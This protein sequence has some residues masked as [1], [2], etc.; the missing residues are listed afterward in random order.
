MENKKVIPL[1]PTPLYVSQINL[2]TNE[3]DF[4]KN[5]N[6]LRVPANNGFMSKDNNI[7]KNKNLKNLNKQ[8]IEHLK[9]YKEEIFSIAN[10]INVFIKH[11]WLMKHVKGDKS[12][13]HFHEN[14]LI[15]GIVYVK[16][17]EKSGNIIFHKKNSVINDVSPLIQLNFNEFNLFNS[18]A[19]NLDIEENMI[20]LFP[21]YLD[22]STEVNDSD[23]ERYCLSFDTFLKGKI[24][25]HDKELEIK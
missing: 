3:I 19:W 2:L 17:P 20:I 7:L 16:T 10:N 9:F 24:K 22:H 18:G 13:K 15:S 1:F 23:D 21:S 12:Q 8:I 25:T 11:S 14:S 5:T 4:I 6:Y